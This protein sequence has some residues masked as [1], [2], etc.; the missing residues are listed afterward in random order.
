MFAQE[1]TGDCFKDC[2]RIVSK[3]I[4]SEREKKQNKHQQRLKKKPGKILKQPFTWPWI[5]HLRFNK[6]LCYHV[7]LDPAAKEFAY[8]PDLDI[9]DAHL[10]QKMSWKG[11]FLARTGGP[12]LFISSTKSP[13]ALHSM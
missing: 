11:W 1:E 7:N 4:D 12:H 13:I 2:A 3:A 5:Q 6:R 10:A 9:K 8:E